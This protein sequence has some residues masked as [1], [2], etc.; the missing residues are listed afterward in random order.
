M[1][2]QVARKYDVVRCYVGVL[3]VVTCCLTKSG[4]VI[5][6]IAV[7]GYVVDGTTSVSRTEQPQLLSAL[8]TFPFPPIDEHELRPDQDLERSCD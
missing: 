7:I 2:K 4:V 6:T 3:Y 1:W 5:L 8:P